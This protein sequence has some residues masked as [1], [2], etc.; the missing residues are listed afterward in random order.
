MRH[1]LLFLP[2]LVAIVG[3]S[4]LGQRD[5][6]DAAPLPAPALDGPVVVELFTSQSCSSCP[7]ADALLGEL[8]QHD[9]IIALGCHVT[10]WD[11]LNWRDTLSRKFCTERQRAYA[12]HMGA[13]Q[14]YTP[15]MVVNGRTEFVGS[16]RTEAT[17]AIAAGTVVPI[18]LTLDTDTLTATLPALAG[19]PSLQTLWLMRTGS[20]H[21]QAIKSGENR[22]K[23]ITYVN[24]VESLEQL[25]T[26]SGAAQTL[27]FPLPKGEAKNPSYVLIAQPQGFGAI[28]AAGRV[29][30]PYP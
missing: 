4:L 10:Y 6:V 20:E 22:G 14:V 15:Q 16:N 28:S 12:R 7:P 1:K 18:Q 29:G 13:A 9:N 24:A 27:S 17:R 3:L 26:W 5:D 2:F 30:I 11:H 19:G 25:G 8:A 21:T 23:T